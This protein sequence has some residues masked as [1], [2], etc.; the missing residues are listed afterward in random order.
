VSTR[1]QLISN[2]LRQRFIE[3]CCDRI[4][5]LGH[6]EFTP[7]EEY[8]SELRERFHN[9]QPGNVKNCIDIPGAWMTSNTD[10]L[11]SLKSLSLGQPLHCHPGKHPPIDSFMTVLGEARDDPE[12]SFRLLVE[13]YA[14]PVNFTLPGEVAVR[15]YVLTRLMVHA[16]A[17]IEKHGVLGADV[18]DLL[19][20]LNLLAVQATL[21][22][23]LR[24]LDALN[25]YY[26]LL[27]ST[28]YPTS[29]HNW[30]LVSYLGLYARA[31]VYLSEAIIECA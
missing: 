28:W 11:T 20:K 23:D 10:C 18:D 29:R 8:V 13:R 24:F 5:R 6:A 21:T 19:L 15:E 14:C 27:P 25:Y 9:A 4:S 17:R 16:R 12:A 26:E 31:L 3:L 30:L 2:A 1:R 7:V 22:T